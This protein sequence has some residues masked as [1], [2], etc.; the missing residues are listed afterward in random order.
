MMPRWCSTA[1]ELALSSWCYVWTTV[2]LPRSWWKNCIVSQNIP[3]VL[4]SVI[5]SCNKQLLSQLVSTS[6]L[7]SS[8]EWPLSFRRRWARSHLV[9]DL[10]SGTYILFQRQWWLPLYEIMLRTKCSKRTLSAGTSVSR[11]SFLLSPRHAWM[12]WK[13]FKQNVRFVR[14]SHKTSE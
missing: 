6:A 1:P 13:V 8:V 3:W 5:Q 12:N 14:K 2:K 7:L 9:S 11:Q 4:T 10:K